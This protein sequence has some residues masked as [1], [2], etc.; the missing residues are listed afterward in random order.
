M[1]CTE[2]LLITALSMDMTMRPFTGVIV[3][4]LFKD[5]VT[6]VMLSPVTFAGL[7]MNKVSQ[8]NGSRILLV[9]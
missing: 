2:A 1:N 6:H 3:S 7:K 8:I 4:E 5:S 9:G